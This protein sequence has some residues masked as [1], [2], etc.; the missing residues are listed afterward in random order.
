MLNRMILSLAAIVLAAPAAA[1]PNYDPSPFGI[2]AIKYEWV[3]R[4]PNGWENAK[5][6]VRAMKGA[7]FYWDRDPIPWPTVQPEKGKWDWSCSDAV[8]RFNREQGINSI[9]LLSGCS[10]WSNNTPPRTAEERAEFAEYVYQMVNRYKDTFKVWEIWNEPNI[11]FFWA[12]PDV[13]LYT[14]L[15]KDAYNAA[16]RADPTCTVLAANTSGPALEFIKGIH[17]NGG[18]DYCDA[19][20]THPYSMAGGPV[21]QKFDRILRIIDDFV[22]STGKPKPHWITEMGWTTSNIREQHNQAIYLVQSYVIA[23]SHGVEKLCWF[24]LD[25]WEEKWGIITNTDPLK[26]KLA[27][28]AAALMTKLFGSP[29]NCAEFEGWLESPEGT[30][31]YVFSKG[32][33]ERLLVL[34]SNDDKTKLVDLKQASGLSA[35]DVFGKPVSCSG[36]TVPVGPA[37]VF[38]SGADARSIGKVSRTANPYIEK[39]GQNLVVNG[40]LDVIH[41]KQTGWWNFGRFESSAKDATFAVSGDGRGGSRCVSISKSGERAA[42]DAVPV[43]VYSGRRYRL[44]AWVKTQEATGATQVG[45]FWYAGNMWTYKGEVRSDPVTG[46][47]EWRKLTVEGTAPDDAMFV[48]VNLI[49][50]KNTGAAW[51]DDVVLTE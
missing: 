13:K 23:L 35:V 33:N 6:P 10:A 51:F 48:R 25:D 7:G 36:G 22:Q 43:P 16:K 34:W 14:L 24:D 15:L 20:C 44:S 19:I 32:G 21:P 26:P 17:D 12:K 47:G 37:P 9:I 1:A 2:N 38:V 27:Y 18:W 45:L 41:G 29:G 4:S 30:A 3:C 40:S 31:C 50:E 8:A 42:C 5:K 49:S 46:T 39:N 11:P 28:G